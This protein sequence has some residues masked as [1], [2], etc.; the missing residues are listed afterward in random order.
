MTRATDADL[1]RYLAGIDEEDLMLRVD[2]GEEIGP[3]MAESAPALEGMSAPRDLGAAADRAVRKL[4]RD[5]ALAPDERLALEAIIIPRERPVFDIIDGTW[6]G[7]VAPWQHFDDPPVRQ[8]LEP[9]LPSIGRVEVP[10]HPAYPYAGTG[11]VVGDGVLMTNRHVAEI[12]TAGLG[13]EG[14]SFLPGRTAGVDFVREIGREDAGEIFMVDKVLMVHP[15]WDMALL[16]VPG[17]GGRAALRLSLMEPEDAIDRDVA[18]VGYPGGSNYPDANGYEVQDRLFRKKYFVKRLLPGRLRPRGEVESYGKLLRAVTHDASTLGGNSGSA[19]LD[20]QTGEVL[21]LH[22]AGQY[23]KTNYAVPSADLARD[24]RVV[25]AGV[26]FGGTPRPEPNIY[27]GEWDVA[28]SAPEAA[29]APAVQVVSTG[30][31][32]AP[33]QAAV[34]ATARITIPLTLDITIGVPQVT[35]AT[36]TA[37]PAPDGDTAVERL[38]IPVADPDYATRR[39]Y[40]P[41]FLGLAVPLPKVRGDVPVSRMAGGEAVIPYHHF[42]LVQHAERRLA[43]FTAANIDAAGAAKEPEPGRDYTRGGLGGLAKN[44]REKWRD[45]GRIPAA[46]QLPDRFYTDDR[47]SFDKGHLVRREA[48]AWGADYEEVRFANGDT[49]HVT[50]CSPQVKGFNR[51]N[52]QGLWGQLENV[53]LKEAGTEKLVVIA[54]PVLAPDDPTFRGRDE[55]GEVRVQI[56]RR[57]FKVIVAR[58]GA[59]LAAF[60][61]LLDQDLSQTDLEFA[62]P[63]EWR[64]RLRSLAEIEE[65]CGGAFA[66]DVILHAADQAGTGRAERMSRD[67]GGTAP[68]PDPGVRTP[69]PAVRTAPTRAGSVT[70]IH[71]IGNKPAADRLAASWVKAIAGGGVDLPAR[72]MAVEMVYWADILYEAPDPVR[73]LVL[74]AEAMME[75]FAGEDV[76]LP[77]D[78]ADEEWMKSLVEGASRGEYTLEDG[79]IVA[80]SPAVARAE[81]PDFLERWFLRRFL[82]DVHHYLYD[83]EFEPRPG[84]RFKVRRDIRER[85]RATLE[86]QM[87]ED[88]PNIIVSH[89]MGTVIAYDVLRSVADCPAVT[90]LVTLGSPL[91]LATI[92]E[93]LDWRRDS[94]FPTARLKGPWVNIFDPFDIVAAGDPEIADDMRKA[95]RKVVKDIAVTNSGSLHHALDAYVT[96]T[97][98]R[99]ELAAMLEAGRA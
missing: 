41:D 18:I 53:V 19:V 81:F 42:S 28:D 57:Y 6:Q 78:P 5:E 17:L 58:E 31:A 62:L 40:D 51:S 85:M 59:G 43:L 90:G 88:G 25:G 73:E 93:R 33:A 37:A 92:Q 89:S 34:A 97:A 13:R 11:F 1:K 44:D 98:F 54:G 94:G 77:Q 8:T 72:N 87:V 12:F 22:F 52:L 66:F 82:R 7:V 70:L 14:L 71:G 80:E 26:C 2:A 21:A 56:P 47:A 10:G 67:L 3:A 23:L 29:A 50:N 75:A 79:R 9:L 20:A 30:T 96:T 35:V 36:P 74:G 49:Y 69:A 86:R 45:E 76:P 64:L 61:F 46:H 83:V 95:R 55:T 27:K 39:G 65:A 32:A 15:Y 24:G 4:A 84:E 38:V 63:R 68:P 60:G 99:D 48:V 91:G 16:A